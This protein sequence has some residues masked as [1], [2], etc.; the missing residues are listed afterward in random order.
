MLLKPVT[1]ESVSFNGST[2]QW[3]CQ[4]PLV[5]SLSIDR[6]DLLSTEALKM[7]PESTNESKTKLSGTFEYM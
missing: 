4:L 5:H 2:V 6:L 7:N 3:L 1:T